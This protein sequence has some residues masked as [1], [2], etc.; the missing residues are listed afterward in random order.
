MVTAFLSHNPA[1]LDKIRRRLTR[2]DLDVGE[3]AGAERHF[4]PDP[5]GLGRHALVEVAE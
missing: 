3:D 2:A 1:D 5:D 4:L